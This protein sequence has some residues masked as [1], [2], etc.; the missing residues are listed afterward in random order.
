MNKLLFSFFAA[1]MVMS[2]FAA[3]ATQAWKIDDFVKQTSKT[4]AEK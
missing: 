3:S 4:Q 1:L 2:S